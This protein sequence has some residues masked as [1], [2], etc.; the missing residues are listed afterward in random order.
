MLASHTNTGLS[1]SQNEKCKCCPYGFHLD[2]DFVSFAENVASGRERR[3]PLE[4]DFKTEKS[5]PQSGNITYGTNDKYFS[6]SGS[7]GSAFKSLSKKSLTDVVNDLSALSHNYDHVTGPSISKTNLNQN[8]LPAQSYRHHQKDMQ[9]PLYNEVP[10]VTAHNAHG[11]LLSSGY[12]NEERTP[13]NE[14]KPQFINEFRVTEQSNAYSPFDPYATLPSTIDQHEHSKTPLTVYAN[15]EVS[16]I[17]S[18]NAKTLPTTLKRVVTS[19]PTS[20]TP[21]KSFYTALG[22]SLANLRTRAPMSP[23]LHKEDTPFSVSTMQSESANRG[24]QY[25]RATKT[26]PPLP[27]RYFEPQKRYPR[28][29]SPEPEK[30]SSPS[31]LHLLAIASPKTFSDAAV[32]VRPELKEI[33]THQQ[34]IVSQFNGQTDTIK[35][36]DRIPVACQTTAFLTTSSLSSETQTNT[37]WLQEKNTNLEK[38]VLETENYQ[39]LVNSNIDKKHNALEITEDNL[40]KLEV[41]DKK[42][43]DTLQSG[44]KLTKTMMIQTEKKINQPIQMLKKT[45]PMSEEEWEFED[46][47]RQVAREAQPQKFPTVVI[48]RTAIKSVEEVIRESEKRKSPQEIQ[49]QEEAEMLANLDRLAT[50]DADRLSIDTDVQ[51]VI[52]LDAINQE[53]KV[54]AIVNEK[55]DHVEIQKNLTPYQTDAIRKLLTEP[56]KGSFQRESGAYRSFKVEK[57]KAS[58]LDYITE[59]HTQVLRPQPSTTPSSD[60]EKPLKEMVVLKKYQNMTSIFPEPISAKIPRP[61]ITKY[62]P[63]PAETEHAETA[64]EAAEAQDKLTP[65]RSELQYFDE[66]RSNRYRRFRRSPYE[67]PPQIDLPDYDSDEEATGYDPNDPVSTSSNSSLTSDEADIDRQSS[68]D[69]NVSLEL[70][71]PLNEALETLNKNLL[72]DPEESMHSTD[73]AEKYVQHEWLRLSTKKNANAEILQQF[74]NALTK[75][76][77]RLL[78]TVIN[79]QDQNGNTALHYAV[80]HENYSVVST[81]LDA[82]VCRVDDTNKAGYSPVMLAALCDIKNE[83][84][85]AIVQRLFERGDVNAKAIY[86]GQTALMLA[87]SHGRIET[88]NLLL[89]CG[90]DVNLKDIDGSTALM[91]AAEHGHKDLVK[92][93]LKRPGI[94]ASLTDCDNQSALSIAMENQH[95]DIGVLIYAHLNYGRS[96]GQE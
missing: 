40:V 93:L 5:K 87:V 24:R 43:N 75:H 15:E 78:E 80:S 54:H 9:R 13:S 74:L 41:T 52:M 2:L 94:D 84:E 89:K 92:I 36:A 86:H 33:G 62:S 8:L 66:W 38:Q 55:G 3:K 61:K 91:C 71:A 77:T 21:G 90:A 70:S 29:L 82:K 85:S 69:E 4:Y 47:E 34:P 39:H 14:H 1:N 22:Q 19:A 23:I 65:L 11:S 76:S 96:D 20:P 27:K 88:T 73:W 60:P 95:R 81:L 26:K 79:F 59:K 45:S 63:Q 56:N 50:I 31:T 42:S 6:P 57:T 32:D 7:N 68:D 37:D 17:F 10:Y 25:E 16:N 35:S 83:T 28:I 46:L 58:D 30:T 51:T 67:T 12:Y 49:E 48:E 18:D 64:D 44:I 72:E 53:K